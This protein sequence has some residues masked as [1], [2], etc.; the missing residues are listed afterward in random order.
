MVTVPTTLHK[1][2]F[3][4]YLPDPGMNTLNTKHTIALGNGRIGMAARIEEFRTIKDGS[5]L[6]VL[7]AISDE[8]RF[9]N[10]IENAQQAD[11]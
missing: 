10:C 3:L 4:Q 6:L 1:C 2:T 11:S 5:I 7:S 8:T 9:E